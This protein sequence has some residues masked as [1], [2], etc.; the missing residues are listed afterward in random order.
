MSSSRDV[1]DRRFANAQVLVWKRVNEEL[2]QSLRSLL[3]VQSQRELSHR[4]LMLR[5]ELYESWRRVEAE[6][7]RSREELS[8]AVAREQFVKSTLLS[9]KLI[10]TKARVQAARAA[11]NEFDVVVGDLVRSSSVE[12]FGQ[13]MHPKARAA[14]AAAGD[15]LDGFD[16]RE[17]VSEEDF[18]LSG[19]GQD[20]EKE[21]KILPF[22]D[23]RRIS[24][25]K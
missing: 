20:G 17:V 22:R 2:S 12:N 14:S 6:L 4:A 13:S 9:E 10:T 16:E 25:G 11:L 8:E 21:G 3:R 19:E 23:V 7:H 15:S 18:S 1:G 5:D 24:S